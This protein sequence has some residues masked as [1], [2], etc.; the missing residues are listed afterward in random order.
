MNVLR[1]VEKGE[2][3]FNTTIPSLVDNFLLK[4]NKTTILQIWDGDKTVEKVTLYNLLHMSSGFKDHDNLRLTL[5]FLEDPYHTPGPLDTLYDCNKH[6]VCLPGDCSH[7]S[8]VNYI[9]LGL[10][11]AQHAGISNWKEL[12]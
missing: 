4:T 3:H 1:L 5:K 6:F 10:V 11:L 12:D 7:Y 2:L 9:V 8:D